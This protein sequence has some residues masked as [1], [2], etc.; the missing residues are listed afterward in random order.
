MATVHTSLDILYLQ[1][2]PFQEG[3]LG[4][5]CHVAPM[6]DLPLVGSGNGHDAEGAIRYLP[7]IGV[8]RGM[9]VQGVD[10]ASVTNHDD[11]FAC[12]PQKQDIVRFTKGVQ[13]VREIEVV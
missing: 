5:M 1:C 7:F 8:T 2:A 4:Q 10:D 6:E 13:G 3:K 12:P 9:L 11:A